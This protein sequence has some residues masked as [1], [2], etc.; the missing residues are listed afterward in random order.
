ML[1]FG[2]Y[3][4]NMIDANAQGSELS[5]MLAR[6]RQTFEVE[7]ETLKVDGAELRILDIR[8]MES[9]L[10]RLIAAKAIDS[11]LRDLPL[12][13][14]LWPGA[15]ILGRFLRR[16]EPQGK[17]LL[18]LGC[19]LGALSLIA[20]GHGFRRILAT[21]KEPL[22]VDFARANTLANGLENIVETRILDVQDKGSLDLRFDM[23]AASELLYLDNLHRPLLRF[24]TR[25]L[26][27]G[28]KA[29]FCTD[30]ARLKPRFLKLARPYFNITE[31]KIGISGSERR[32]YSILILESK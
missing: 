21:D 29:F 13:A 6:I 15:L 24:L 30:T 9:H 27:P 22:A 19:G 12:W 17:T 1:S 2:R 25:H 16:F 32:L 5:A 14:K 10:N 28:G 3:C 31:G 23:I 18:E 4:S 11:P 26:A 8:N 20:A 7:F